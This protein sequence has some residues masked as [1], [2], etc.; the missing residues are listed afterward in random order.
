[1]KISGRPLSDLQKKN[2]LSMILVIITLRFIS[3]DFTKTTMKQGLKRLRLKDIK[4]IGQT[5]ISRINLD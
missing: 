3:I 2:T 1:M 4:F 5:L